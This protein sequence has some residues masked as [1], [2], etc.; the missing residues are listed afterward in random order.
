MRHC[1]HLPKLL[2]LLAFA[3]VGTAASVGCRNAAY[4]EL[5]VQNMAAEIRDL[6]D[7]LYE[8]DNEYHV[9]EQQLQTLRAENQ[10][11]RLNPVPASK[12]PSQTLQPLGEELPP[13]DFSPRNPASEP[14]TRADTPKI[15]G[16]QKPLQA[17]SILEPPGANGSLPDAKQLQESLPTLPS[18]QGPEEITPDLLDVPTIIPGT[19]QP[20]ALPVSRTFSDAG[21]KPLRPD[22]ELN[23]SRIEIPAQLASG[24][25]PAQLKMAS[26]LPSDLRIVEIAFHPTLTRAANFDD[27]PD[28]DGLYLVLQPKN[29]AGEVVPTPA[30]LDIAVLDPSRDE[31]AARIGRWTYSAAE[32][33]AKFQ[34]LG[35]H[36]GIHL[37]LPW[38]GPDPGADRVVVFVRY[39]FPDGRQVVNDKTIFVSGAGSLKTVWVPR[40]L[41]GSAVVP[42]S[43]AQE[44]PARAPVV[45]PSGVT[46]EPAPRPNE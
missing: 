41:D 6:E 9:L 38:N 34:P 20:P 22:M 19:P 28:D 15:L 5:Y 14:A 10:R 43:H 11:L 36:Q 32:V 39:T 27:E 46:H 30:T 17:E 21:A 4:S 12:L 3:L 24:R 23:L 26:Q 16:S 42:A 13:R 35:N 8:Y 33:K 37:T 1:L 18:K 31:N 40:S 2:L 7:Q 45:R 44:E 29:V 25:E